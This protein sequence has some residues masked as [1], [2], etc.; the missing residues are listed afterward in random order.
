[1]NKIS[2]EKVFEKG[3]IRKE[4]FEENFLNKFFE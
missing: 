1:L 3:K 4:F 2:E